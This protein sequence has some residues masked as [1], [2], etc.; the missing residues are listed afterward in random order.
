MTEY[1]HKGGT[2]L[3]AEG[4]MP[5]G[6]FRPAIAGICGAPENQVA[7]GPHS[8]SKVG[9]AHHAAGPYMHPVDGLFAPD[10]EERPIKAR[11]E[12]DSVE[13]ST[14]GRLR[15]VF[16]CGIEGEEGSWPFAIELHEMTEEYGR[17]GAVGVPFLRLI[18]SALELE[19]A[20]VRHLAMAVNPE[21]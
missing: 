9:D 21:A 15:F 4:W 20:R 2:P 14:T 5:F 11:A 3:D 17:D 19:A 1:D 8:M 12:L 7:N 6:E 13:L 16:D 18:A 10:S